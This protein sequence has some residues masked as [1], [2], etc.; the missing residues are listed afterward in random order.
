MPGVESHGYTR[1]RPHAEDF[2]KPLQ[3]RGKS[4]FTNG[5]FVRVSIP[6]TN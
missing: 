2:N 5:S 1:S 3:E 6:V 4:P